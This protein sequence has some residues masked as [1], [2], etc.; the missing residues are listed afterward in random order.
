VVGP[1]WRAVPDVSMLADVDPGYAVYCSAS[2]CVANHTPAWQSVGGTSAAAPLLAG[3]LALVDQWL[4]MH[5]RQDLGFL[6]P[7]LYRVGRSASLA[8]KVLGDVVRYDNDVGPFIPGDHMPLG[9]CQAR[10]GFDEASGWGSVNMAGLA[11]VALAAEPRVASVSLSL[12]AHQHPVR[13]GAILATVG[14][15]RACR[16]GGFAEVTIGHSFPFAV[17]SRV[18]R[19]GS[20]GKRT[21]AMTFSP[22]QRGRLRAALSR[23]Q[24]IAAQVFG[25]TVNA[26][27]VIQKESGGKRIAI[28]G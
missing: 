28:T 14:C 24:P 10:S 11:G 6:N 13:R 17:F 4:R 18:Y 27:G 1:N 22:G 23:G 3:G 15:S 9:C 5:E 26:S 7:L 12:P 8:P 16:M 25:A 21:I 2:D 19:L 20:A